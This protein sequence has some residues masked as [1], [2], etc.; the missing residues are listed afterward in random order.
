V[1]V[2]ERA[3]N[4][5]NTNARVF[6]RY[7][8]AINLGYPQ[9]TAGTRIADIATHALWSE[10]SIQTSGLTMQPQ[11]KH[12]QPKLDEISE[13]AHGEGPR[14]MFFFKGT[15]DPVYLG[16]NWMETTAAYNTVQATFGDNPG[17]VGYE[18]IELVYD[19]ET[20]NEVNASKQGGELVTV[21]D[22][23][24]QGRRSRRARSEETDLLLSDDEDVEAVAG[25]ALELY[26]E[27]AFRAKT[28]T[29]N[30]AGGRVVQLF[31]REIGHMIRVKRSSGTATINRIC[32]IIGKRKSLGPDKHLVCTY[33][34]SRGYDGADT[35]WLLGISGR[36]ELTSTAVLA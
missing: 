35:D 14:T 29:V 18:G 11:M 27:P 26:K 9:Q 25:E 2:Y 10:A 36:T 32:H 21:S 5:T 8:A 20:F 16:W 12:G 13:L 30:G 34:L 6:A 7:N 1:A 17:E 15:G 3:I 33:S 31:D 19:N 4:A 24:A 23:T 22:A 28:I